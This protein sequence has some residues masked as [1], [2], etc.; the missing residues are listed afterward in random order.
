MDKHMVILVMVMFFA[1]GLG[2]LIN[3]YSKD[4][5]KNMRKS[6]ILGIGA[7]S[8]VPLFLNMIS[9]SLLVDS[10]KDPHKILV[11]MGF[12]LIAAISSKAFIGTI[13]DRIMEKIQET[14][15]KIEDVKEVIDPIANKETEQDSAEGQYSEIFESPAIGEKEKAILI[16]MNKGEYTY[17]TASSISDDIGMSTPSTVTLLVNL[18]SLGLVGQLLKTGKTLY[19]LSELGRKFVF[20]LGGSSK[21]DFNDELE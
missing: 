3:Y 9:S 12:C 6:L 18:K 2:G 21:R 16:T 20:A 7:S 10:G 19:Y 11:F 15:Q 17:R 5:E 13:S 4:E 14:D 1:G 8:L